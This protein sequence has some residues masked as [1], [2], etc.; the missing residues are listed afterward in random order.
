[1]KEVRKIA[2]SKIDKL[3]YVPESL[4]ENAKIIHRKGDIIKKK[5]LFKKE[6]RAKADIWDFGT[7]TTSVD[8]TCDWLVEHSGKL[9]YTAYVVID[10]ECIRFSSNEE[11]L[12]FYNKLITDFNLKIII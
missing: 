5:G 6:K 3:I 7:Y 4:V 12:E 2:V 11:A 1:M 8:D 9:Y 10:D